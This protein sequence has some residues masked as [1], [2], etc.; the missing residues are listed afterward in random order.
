METAVHTVIQTRDQA[1]S[2]ARHEDQDEE[3]DEEDDVFE[4]NP[5]ARIGDQNQQRAVIEAAGFDTRRWESGFR[6]DLPEFSG[7]LQPD[8]FLDWI[9]TTK[10]LL[11]FKRVPD[12]MRIHLVATRF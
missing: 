1:P 6:L 5:F 12:E 9:S 8:Q 4:N 3:D 2:L 7:S 11:N 10:E